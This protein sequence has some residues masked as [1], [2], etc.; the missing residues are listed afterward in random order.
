MS[1]GHMGNQTYS[2]ESL[3]PPSKLSSGKPSARGLGFT[4]GKYLTDLPQGMSKKT[5]NRPRKCVP[6]NP[7]R[8]SNVCP[9]ALNKINVNLWQVYFML[10]Q[11][12]QMSRQS[13][14]NKNI[15]SKLSIGHTK[16]SEKFIFKCHF[17]IGWFYV[18]IFRIGYNVFSTCSFI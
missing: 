15:L 7:S 1:G 3:K 9:R 14:V 2:Q 4:F 8:L 13:T 16:I 17:D 18:I 6:D 10:F 11:R 5:Q 12:C